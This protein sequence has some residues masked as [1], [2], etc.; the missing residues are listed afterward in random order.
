MLLLAILLFSIAAFLGV[1]L[2]T[3][4][5]Q[6]KNTPKSVAFIHGPIAATGLII[7]IIYAFLYKPAPIVSIIIFILAALEGAILIY[8][9]ITGKSLPKWLAI[10]HGLT[11]IIGFVFLILFTFKV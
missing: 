9:D 3:Y 6:N 1:Y 2:L 4:V 5:L 11:A 7:L 10:G 8:R